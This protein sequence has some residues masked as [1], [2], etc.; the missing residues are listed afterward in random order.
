MVVLLVR[1][2][3]SPYKGSTQMARAIT[4]QLLVLY[5]AHLA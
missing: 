2:R 1:C 3:K 4:C 5:Q